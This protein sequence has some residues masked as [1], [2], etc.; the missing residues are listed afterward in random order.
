QQIII[1]DVPESIVFFGRTGEG[2]S[3]LANMLIQEDLCFECSKNI[4]P[5]SDNAVGE[6]SE[7]KYS[8]N[9]AFEIYD[10]IGLCETSKGTISHKQAIKKIRYF[11][12]KTKSP[13]NYICYVKKKSRFTKEDQKAFKKFKNI[14]KEGENNFVIIMTDCTPKWASDNVKTIRDYF[15]NH[16]IIAVDFPFDDRFDAEAQKKIRIESRKH[17]I[18]CLMHLRYNCVKLEIAGP[19][20]YFES[21]VKKVMDFVPVVGT[22]YNLISSG[23]YFIL[24]KP[25]LAKRRL[26][27]GAGDLSKILSK[28]AMKL[29]TNS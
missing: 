22:A 23:A 15:G 2:K 25:E 9:D 1:M 7:V 27:E 24:R 12:S 8:K 19:K 21:K 17:L 16:P 4:F 26:I 11:F 29:L 14:F 20:E 13:L 28:V 18:S 6:T 10:T 5:I 3:T